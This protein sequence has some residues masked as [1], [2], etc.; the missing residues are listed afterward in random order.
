MGELNQ[1]EEVFAQEFV[2]NG[3]N[4]TE[5]WRKANPNSKAKVD[6]QYS[7]ASTMLAKEKVKERI[8]VLKGKARR[9]A[10]ERFCITVEQRLKWLKDITEAG[11][12]TYI[13]QNQNKR[14]TE[15][16]FNN[17]LMPDFTNPKACSWWLEKRRY[18]V[19]QLGVAGFKTDG[20]EFLFNTE[21]RLFNGQTGSAAHNAYP[22]AYEGAYH[23][24]LDET[25]GKGEG[26]LFSRAGFTGAQKSPIHWAGDQ[27]ST[28]GELEAQLK[29]GL[30]LGL[31]GVPFWG[32]DIGGF[33]GELPST[34]LYLRSAA[35]GA[36]APVMQFHSEPR[37]GQYYMTDRK[38]WNNDRSPWNLASVQE[39]E[40]ILTVYRLF[41]NLRMNLLPYLWQEARHSAKTARP[42]MAHLISDFAKTDLESVRAIEDEYML[43]RSLLVAP[44]IREGAAGRSV[45]LPSGSWRDFYTGELLSGGRTIE[46]VCE[47]NRIPVFARN[48]TDIPVNANGALV[49]GSEGKEGA[50]SNRTDAYERLGFLLYGEPKEICFADDLGNDFMLTRGKLGYV[51][52]GRLVNSLA[53][54]DMTRSGA[55][56]G[57]A[58]VFGRSVP[59]TVIPQNTESNA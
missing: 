50:V 16:W 38:A 49:I 45:Y 25:R 44:V 35:F 1:K 14:I 21:A 12:D 53:L 24:F 27:V 6:V 56:S 19:E 32:F 47:L 41:A 10:E 4:A 9:K 34:E 31:S 2:L 22:G 48:N 15:M 52:S 46:V 57:A 13:D 3:G 33:A 39:D 28:F 54:I 29:A 20:G 26:V 40:R 17:S 43:G 8:E 58:K 18:L 55:E 59:V 23:T 42:M 37:N 11:L 51:L 36:F 30:S 5:A 7:K